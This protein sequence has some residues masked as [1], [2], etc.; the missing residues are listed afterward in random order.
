[1]DQV[2]RAF[3]DKGDQSPG[4]TDL[5]K[6]DLLE[7]LFGTL[8][9]DV[10]DHTHIDPFKNKKSA[11]EGYQ[12][13][14]SSLLLPLFATKIFSLAQI[15]H[16]FNDTNF[17]ENNQTRLKLMAPGIQTLAFFVRMLKFV[18]TNAESEVNVMINAARVKFVD[19]LKEKQKAM[20][21]F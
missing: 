21:N 1:M 3:E 7:Y 15:R 18:D 19:G 16:Q 8:L 2:I 6:Q 9:K 5:Q 10:A 13:F 4:I 12:L 17:T 14:E 11:V 20:K